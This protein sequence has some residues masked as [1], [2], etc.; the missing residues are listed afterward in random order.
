MAEGELARRIAGFPVVTC[1]VFDTALLRRLAR[2][3]DVLLALGL[4]A[5]AAGL[6]TGPPEAF[7]E[8]RLQAERQA[9]AAAE[10]AGHDE[11]RIAEVYACFQACGLLPNGVTD[12]AAAAALAAL[13]LATER[14]VC[15]ANLLLRAVLAARAPGQRLVFVSDTMLPGAAVATLLQDAGYGAD[16]EVIT[17]ADTRRSKHTGKLF[18][19]V[20][21]RLGCAPGAVVHLGDNPHSDVARPRTQG[22][23]AIH[24]P[25]PPRPPEPSALAAAAAL[26]RLAHSYCRSAAEHSQRRSAAATPAADPGAPALHPYA[27][28]LLL[29]FTRFVLAEAQ[30]Q[31]IRRIYFLARDGYLPWRI[32]QRMAPSLQ[33][34][35]LGSDVELTY[36]HVSRRAIGLPAQAADLDA[37]AEDVSQGAHYR[38]LAEALAFLGLD[39]AETAALIRDR[40]LDPERPVGHATAR[41]EVAALFA[42]CREPIRARLAERRVTALAY[43]GQQGFLEPGPRLVVDVGWRGST[44]ESLAR[45]TGLPA[46]DI[47]GAYVGLFPQHLRPAVNPANATGYLFNFGHPR[48]L[49]ELVLEGYVLFEL[50]FSSPEATVLHY[51]MRDGAPVPVLDAEAEPGASIRR[52]AIAALEADCLAECAALDGILGGAWPEVDPASALFDL[53]GLLAAPTAAEVAALNAIPFI[54]GLSRGGNGVPVNPVPPHE[55]LRDPTATVQRIGRAAWRSG[56]LRASLPWPWPAMRFQDLEYRVARLRRLL[57]LK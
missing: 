13:E 49:L 27:T 3:E 53:Q 12:E 6:F 39:A 18:A 21:E 4:R 50:F 7:R 19:H 9:R 5:A 54:G 22:I 10:A 16:C 37:L 51:A 55:W 36:L 42:A 56:T 17:S 29:G 35:G 48:P 23:A 14:A 1:D 41:A 20:L 31:G 40:G 38:P 43:L 2:P 52:R 57:R 44:Q 34:A 33:A 11:V 30:R 15:T 47:R 28:L 45:L 32:A 46:S 8:Y 24:L 25:Q 26:T